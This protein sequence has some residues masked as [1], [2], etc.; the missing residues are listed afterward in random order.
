M[1]VTIDLEGKRGT[2]YQ[3][4]FSLDQLTNNVFV[5]LRQPMADGHVRELAST[6]E[7][8]GGVGGR[9]MGAWFG[10]VK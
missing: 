10:D 3:L 8:R 7:A 5:E 6:L 2:K 1:Q 4:R 9:L